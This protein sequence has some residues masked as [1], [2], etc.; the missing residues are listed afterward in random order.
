MKFE[1]NSCSQKYDSK[2]IIEINTLEELL[3]YVKK[4]EHPI[5]IAHSIMEDKN[6]EK[7]CKYSL[8]TYDDYRE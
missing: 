3:E 8:E 6:K 5:I 2:P 1:Q 4:E 7:G